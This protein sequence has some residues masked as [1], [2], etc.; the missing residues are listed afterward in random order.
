LIYLLLFIFVRHFRYV[1][2]Y[3]AFISTHLVIV[4]VVLL[5]HTYETHPG[6]LLKSGWDMVTTRTTPICDELTFVLNLIDAMYFLLIVMH[7]DVFVVYCERFVSI[8]GGLCWIYEE[9]WWIVI[10]VVELCCCEKL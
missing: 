1:I 3:V 5:W 9:F 4:C 6:L 8:C 2:K 7:S 10:F